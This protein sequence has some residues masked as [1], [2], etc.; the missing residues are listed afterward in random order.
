[1]CWDIALTVPDLCSHSVLYCSLISND[2]S[3]VPKQLHCQSHHWECPRGQICMPVT[4]K[5]QIWHDN[6][7]WLAGWGSLQR[8]LLPAMGDMTN[9]VFLIYSHNLPYFTRTWQVI[10]LREGQFFAAF[11]L[12]SYLME[13]ESSAVGKGIQSN[14]CRCCSLSPALL[15][16]HDVFLSVFKIPS[17][18]DKLGWC[19]SV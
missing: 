5:D 12:P 14:M 17:N 18:A 11:Q 1:M 7:C 6:P 16:R 13:R 15:C 2:N 19:S 4:Q 9:F 10:N 8:Q 3:L